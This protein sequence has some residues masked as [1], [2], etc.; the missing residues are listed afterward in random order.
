MRRWA[1]GT[2]AALA[3]LAALLPA[4]AVA[5][6]AGSV[7]DARA[8]RSAGLAVTWPLAGPAVTVAPGTRLAVG[9]RKLRRSAPVATVALLRVGSTGRALRVVATRR[10]RS[11]RVALTVPAT[12][13]GGAHYALRLRAGRLTYAGWIDPPPP[14]PAPAPAPA[15][16]PAPAPNP[17]PDPCPVSAGTP[18]ATLTLDAGYLPVGGTVGYAIAD[19]GP[20]CISIGV[21][22]SWQRQDGDRWTDVPSTKAFPALALLLR[23]GQSYRG[24]ASPEASMTPGHYRL[25]TGY[26]GEPLRAPATSGPVLT[27]EVDVVPQRID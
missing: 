10:V 11:G 8:L 19:T 4:A 6:P 2:I 7:P 15:P 23:P 25:V 13:P 22:Y 18:A 14:A 12:G 3:A 17:N 26:L 21:G 27:A 1:S 16:L 9:V 5:R 20:T 24:S